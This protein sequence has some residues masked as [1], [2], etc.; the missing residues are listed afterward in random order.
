LANLSFG[1]K[2]RSGRLD[3]VWGFDARSPVNSS[4]LIADVDGDGKKEIVLGTKEGKVIVLDLAAGLKWF[5]DTNDKKSEVEMMFLDTESSA[6]IGATPNH[7][8][9][10]KDGK[11][12][13]LFG[14]ELGVLYCLDYQGKLLWK[15]KS[16]GGIRGQVIICDLLGDGRPK[17]IFG[18]MDGKIKVL[19]GTGK[20]VWYFDAGVGVEGTPGILEKGGQRF[21]VIG[22]DDGTV[23]CLNNRGDATWKF[24]TGAKVLAQPAFA[25]LSNDGRTNIII[26]SSDNYMYCLDDAGELIWKYRTE[27]AIIAKAAIKDINDDKHP[28]VVFGSCDN[29]VYCLSYQ[30]DKMWSYETDFWIGSEPILEDIDGD[31]KPEV[32]VGSYDHNIYV[33]DSEGSYVLEYVPGLSGIVNQTGHYS[34]IITKEPGQTSGKKIWQFKTEGV[35]VGTAYVP[36]SKSVV[37]STKPG[38]VNTIKHK[39]E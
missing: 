19:D 34:D 26:G 36:E 16:D 10:N 39:S 8:D 11:N 2:K 38:K 30:G 28:E 17:V 9:V 14:T 20:L 24:K 1:F 33:L 15:N 5:Y 6:S 7:G 18:T 25:S 22:C 37:V 21:V 32:I 29:R 27:G 23:Y 4:P 12:E 13:V 35:I 31:G 3:Q